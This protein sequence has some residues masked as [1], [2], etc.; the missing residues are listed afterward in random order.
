MNDQ[1]STTNAVCLAVKRHHF[2][3]DLRPQ[4]TVLSD[5]LFGH[6]AGM[7]TLCRQQTVLGLRRIKVLPSRIMTLGRVA[8]A[9][10][11]DMD[12]KPLVCRKAGYLDFD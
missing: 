5:I 11:V 10:L 9:S 1:R 7:R 2:V 3:E 8:I 6:I 12:R 4:N